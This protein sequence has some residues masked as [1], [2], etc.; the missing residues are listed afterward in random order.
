MSTIKVFSTTTCVFRNKLKSC[1]TKN[2]FAY[3]EVLID[4]HHEEAQTSFAVCGVDGRHARKSC[5]MMAE[6]STY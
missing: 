4:K 6:K 1:L 2:N 5:A 3:E